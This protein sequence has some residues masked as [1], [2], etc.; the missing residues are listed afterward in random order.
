[1]GQIDVFKRVMSERGNDEYCLLWKQ[2]TEKS[3]L[4]WIKMQYILVAMDII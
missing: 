3:W 2:I 4:P 1:M